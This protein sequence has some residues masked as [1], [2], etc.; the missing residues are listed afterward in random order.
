M[1]QIYDKF[2]VNKLK[3]GPTD[4]RD[5]CTEEA[6]DGQYFHLGCPEV[7]SRM[8]VEKAKGAAAT[9][10]E[11]NSYMEWLLC[12]WDP[13]YRMELVANDIRVDREGVGVEL[14]AVPWYSQT[15]KD[16]AAMY[17]TCS[18]G[19]QYEELLETEGHL[20]ER[21]Y[22]MVKFCD[23]RYAQ[24]KLKAY[25]N[26]ETNYKTYRRAWGGSNT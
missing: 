8:V 26:F 17:A 18:Y 2:F 25:I 1:S 10:D 21:W 3:L 13:T 6:F 15:P 22:A 12:T 20:G 24:S 19:K 5:R 16:I 14:M 7:F 9:V 23:S 11:V 4:I